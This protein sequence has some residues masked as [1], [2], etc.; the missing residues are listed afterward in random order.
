MVYN[1]DKKKNRIFWVYAEINE[2]LNK[3]IHGE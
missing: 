2:L 3:Q 1:P